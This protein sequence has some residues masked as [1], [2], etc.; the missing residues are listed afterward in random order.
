MRLIRYRKHAPH[1]K[2][3]KCK[4]PGCPHVEG[5]NTTHDLERH[6]KSKHPSTILGMLDKRYRCHVPGCKSY[7]K[8]WPNLEC[9]R[10]HLK[11]IHR[12]EYLCYE[13]MTESLE[14]EEFQTGDLA[15]S[16]VVAEHQESLI[17][18]SM[19]SQEGPVQV[20]GNT[21]GSPFEIYR[22]NLWE[23]AVEFGTVCYPQI[24]E[25]V[26]P[27]VSSVP[28]SSISSEATGQIL[29]GNS[30]YRLPVS[31]L[32]NYSGV[33]EESRN[34]IVPPLP[35]LLPPGSSTKS[36]KSS[37]IKEIEPPK[38]PKKFK[39]PCNLCEKRFTRSTT[40]RE[41]TR[42]H[43]NERPFTCVGF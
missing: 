12:D 7:D 20:G 18:G 38:D 36:R 16:A 41:H 6:T 13:M 17:N 22:R 27:V 21:M 11:R 37:K 25:H 23:N 32:D 33:Q 34:A 26:L 35:Y 3:F 1:R 15:D 8:A 29:T 43:K 9:F 42:T 31:E 30:S 40:L 19:A 14:G 2:P 39:F 24:P 10:S 28:R 5:F 4:I